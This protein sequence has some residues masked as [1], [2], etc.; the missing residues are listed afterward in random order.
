MYHITATETLIDFCFITMTHCELISNTSL[1]H[2]G[3]CHEEMQAWRK[4]W[5]NYENYEMTKAPLFTWI[6]SPAASQ[7]YIQSD[8]REMEKEKKTHWAP[9]INSP[10]WHLAWKTERSWRLAHV[11]RYDLMSQFNSY[12]PRYD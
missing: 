10:L 5:K 2:R 8:H 7:L 3:F 4:L 1:S 9:L 12:P 11:W 6:S